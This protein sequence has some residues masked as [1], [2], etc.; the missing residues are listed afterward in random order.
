MQHKKSGMSLIEVIVGSA[1]IVSSMV[2]IIG[3]YG[4]LT[5]LSLRNMPK[6][7]AAMLL[8]EGAEILRLMRDSGWS[9]KIGTLSNGTTYRFVWQNNAWTSTTSTQ[10]IDNFFD[11]TFV[12][13]TV[14]RDAS[15]NIVTSGGT[16]DTGTKKAT[17]Y[18]SWRDGAATTTKSVELYIYNTFSN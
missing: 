11:R 14:N 6:V 10:M 9:S 15:H 5:N 13:S 1:I 3:V 8:E 2:S 7:Q 12:L 16:L 18:V 17:M 4:G